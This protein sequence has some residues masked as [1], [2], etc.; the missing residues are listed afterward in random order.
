[1]AALMVVLIGGVK[2]GEQE[3][4]ECEVEGNFDSRGAAK[5][6]ESKRQSAIDSCESIVIES[7]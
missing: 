1:M 5:A 4:D 3:A 2:L 7:V 6:V